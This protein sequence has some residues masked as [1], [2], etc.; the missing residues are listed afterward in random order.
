M[1]EREKYEALQRVYEARL[2]SL[3]SSVRKV[4]LAVRQDEV[5]LAIKEQPGLE[6]QYQQHL[7]EIVE[8]ELG[9][10]REDF[11]Q[12]LAGR[13]SSLEH[14][15]TV[16]RRR[17]AELESTVTAQKER[18]QSTVAA[19]EVLQKSSA[20]AEQ[21][22]GAALKEAAT[23]CQKA[24]SENQRLGRE[25]AAALDELDS[26]SSG[27]HHAREKEMQLQQQLDAA[28]A[29]SQ[30]VLAKL[31]ASEARA[32]N[33]QAELAEQQRAGAASSAEVLVLSERLNASEARGSE[34]KN[35]LSR[36]QRQL[37]RWCIEGA[38][39]PQVLQCSE[40]LFTL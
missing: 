16:S 2:D 25:L 35:Q 6:P 3:T 37:V 17:I 8:T 36:T 14:E 30:D 7:A 24:T 19:A 23:K 32:A 1:S 22:S 34:A 20:E 31:L 40:G 11:L 28:T 4:Y 12:R 21:A 27:F 26:A 33:L 10:E 39:N 9:Q 15:L 38:H 13:C 18:E 5:S 29:R